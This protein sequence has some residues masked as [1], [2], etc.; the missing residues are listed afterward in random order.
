MMVGLGDQDG[1][2]RRL[3]GDLVVAYQVREGE[4]TQVT[5]V[6]HR[7]NSQ[8]FDKKDQPGQTHFLEASLVY[9]GTWPVLEPVG[10]VGHSVSCPSSS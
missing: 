9:P 8:S 10:H 5:K 4:V 3:S 6:G 2:G 1:T 7:E